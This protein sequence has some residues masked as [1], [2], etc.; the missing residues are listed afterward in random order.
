MESGCPHLASVFAIQFRY[1]FERNRK[2]SAVAVMHQCSWNISHH[3]IDQADI[4]R[5]NEGIGAM[6]SRGWTMDGFDELHHSFDILLV[7]KIDLSHDTQ[8]ICCT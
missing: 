5:W 6:L 2:I 4:V 1:F 8:K 3:L 7:G